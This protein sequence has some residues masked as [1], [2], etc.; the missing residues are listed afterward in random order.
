MWNECG[1]VL[2]CTAPTDPYDFNVTITPDPDIIGNGVQ[3]FPFVL[4]AQLLTITKFEGPRWIYGHC[5]YYI[6]G[7][8]LWLPISLASRRV[9]QRIGQPPAHF[10]RRVYSTSCT[11]AAP[12]HT[13][14]EPKSQARAPR[15]ST[16]TQPS[17]QGPEQKAKDEMK[18]ELLQRFILALSDQ[19]LITGFAILVAGILKSCTIT[20]WEFQV[21][22]SLAWFS[23][24]THL[25]TLVVL[26]GYLQDHPTVRNWRVGGMLVILGLLFFGVLTKVALL[27]EYQITGQ[28]E[29]VFMS[30]SAGLRD[31]PG[32]TVPI[33]LVFL[34]FAYANQ[35][36]K[37]FSE[38][39]QNTTFKVLD[40][41]ITRECIRLFTGTSRKAWRD[42]Y[43]KVI[44]LQAKN[45]LSINR[46]KWKTQMEKRTLRQQK[47]YKAQVMCLSAMSLL[48]TASNLYL[49]SFVWQ[50]VWLI[51][52]LS[53]GI[54][55]LVNVRWQNSPPL[56][57]G[58]GRMD[59]GQIVPLLLLVLPVLAAGE[60]YYEWKDK[61]NGRKSRR[62]RNRSE[63]SLQIGVPSEPE[64]ND[65]LLSQ[66]VDSQT[67]ESTLSQYTH[68]E[69]I[70][71]PPSRNNSSVDSLRHDSLES[72][73]NIHGVRLAED[74]YFETAWYL[75]YLSD[76]PPLEGVAGKMLLRI[77]AFL[78]V[79][80]TFG[81]V[82]FA[83]SLQGF[84][85]VPILDPHFFLLWICALL[86][87]FEVLVIFS[88]VVSGFVAIRKEK[89]KEQSQ[90]NPQNNDRREARADV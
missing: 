53:Y 15:N 13:K 36:V 84:L 35:L 81:L 10:V 25:S 58:V 64:Q 69:H 26:W 63:I 90:Q 9:L 3:I 4:K 56:A 34:F 70:P 60:A 28:M 49:E 8:G 27:E 45:R 80:S 21:V 6:F 2:N 17:G 52:G 48:A 16:S 66:Q 5:V 18:I 82:L 71:L 20:W 50:I 38:N 62:M 73:N 43:S 77:A 55:Q 24:T 85:I 54:A 59:F 57:P 11:P 39:R 74:I 41:Y 89:R 32:Y 67:P 46:R 30:M 72:S 22:V 37:L 44:E 65:T 61:R 7:G 76:K 78:I 23:S 75:W 14:M 68:A 47:R 29:C 19:Q 42:K 83:I 40:G 12:S 33:V 86:V 87:Y 51:F 1:S 31:D 88:K 79:V